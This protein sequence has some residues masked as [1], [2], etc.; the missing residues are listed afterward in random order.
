MDALRFRIA[1]GE[2]E[3][4]AEVL[5]PL[6][7]ILAPIFPELPRKRAESDNAPERPFGLIYGVL[8][9]LA[10]HDP[11]LLVLEDIH[12][13]D[14]TS[15]DLLQRIA[16]RAGALRLMV[17]ATYRSD[18]LPATHP[19]RR[20]LAS[21]SRDR[22]G[23]I[24]TLDPLT[25]EATA[26][27]LRQMLAAEPH[28]DF[29]S[30]IWSRTEGNPFFVEE[31]LNALAAGGTIE[32]NAEEARRI[33]GSRLPDTVSE[34]VMT[35]VHA[36]GTRAV[37]T[38]S[39]AAIMGRT[40][41]FDLLR[42]AL[43][44]PE[45][46]LL[47]IV[48]KLVAHQLLREERIAGKD[49][50][51]F[52][53]A[54]LQEAL[55]QSVISRRRRLLHKQIA[56]L[57][58]GRSL[59]VTPEGLDRLAYHY[60]QGGEHE[61]AYEYSL[62][63]GDDAVRLR[64][65]NDAITYYECA[66]EA[67]EELKDPGIRSSPLLEKL[68]DVAW[69][70]GN[71]ARA[72]QYLEE[73]LRIC[74]TLNDPD[75]A[76]RMLRRVASLSVQG[77]EEAY[78]AQAL[79]EALQIVRNS[80]HSPELAGILDDLGR[81]SLLSGD[82]GSAESL[83]LKGLSANAP[84]ARGP[85]EVR[86]MV[87]L[88]EIAVL[89][90]ET[91]AAMN[92]FDVAFE[93]LREDNLPV[94]RA[95]EVYTSAIHSLITAQAY[96]RAL[97]WANEAVSLCAEHGL[98]PLVALNGSMRAAVLTVTGSSEDTLQ[99]ATAAAT[100]LRAAQSGHLRDALRVLGF[101]HRVRGD[102]TQARKFY[103]EARSLGER[104]SSVGLALISLA[105]GNP[106][107]ASAVIREVMGAA[108]DT[109][110]I[111]S[112]QLLPFAVEAILGSDDF[113]GAAALLRKMESRWPVA[114]QNAELQYARGLI[115]L[116]TGKAKAAIKSLENAASSW[117]SV[118]NRLMAA[119]AKCAELDAMFAAGLV[120]GAEALG[121]SLL[122]E[123][124]A[125]RFP[126]E[127]EQVRRSLRRAGIRT[128]PDSQAASTGSG[129]KTVLTERE[130]AV[131]HEVAKGRTNREIANNLGIAEKTV[132]VHVSHILAKLHCKTRT[133]AARFVVG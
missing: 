115:Q 6:R 78:A 129:T 27:M 62:L 1:R 68:A 81:L 52:S 23:E 60:R 33:H 84:D 99:L 31:I 95:V 15:L 73:A 17:V 76:A 126:R 11:M 89:R 113:T 34:V 93:V 13:A 132:S 122:T 108:P 91:D 38:L 56:T 96:D 101:V 32:P 41:E 4:V 85:E 16:H 57:L 58:D 40:V 121:R 7:E 80:P 65:W 112:L 51:T 87:G 94:D 8:E 90:G 98:A 54:L 64:A 3:A 77:G 131:L 130:T 100:E 5:G 67:L 114:K 86:A 49:H 25:R 109:H 70:Q 10:G 120:E 106:R 37:E 44:M 28:P 63:A 35:R 103:E 69:R 117:S 36:L 2:S 110:V 118:N 45:E 29:V 104:S 43:G 61:K 124:E 59:P 46:E 97:L 79:D 71:A 74:R 111:R 105:E 75:S 50:Y 72:R 88:G 39:V 48:E 66:L 9:K 82:L 133:E 47:D 102:L 92:M 22:T 18:E 14:K 42:E 55:Y 24:I 30:A 128:K 119:R 21:F 20:V 26:E 116:R 107:E 125:S 12:W 19:L 123:M 127:R 83:L 53:H